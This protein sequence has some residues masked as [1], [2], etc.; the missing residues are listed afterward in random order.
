MWEKE[1]IPGEHKVYRWVKNS[2][3][4]DGE[5]APGAF[6]NATDENGNKTDGMSVNWEEYSTCLSTRDDL[7]NYGKNREEYGV[8][9]INVGE[10]R[11]KIDPSQEVE[12]AP[13]LNNS[14]HSEV[15]GDK[16]K[17]TQKMLRDVASVCVLPV[18]QWIPA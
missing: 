5:V 7:I 8:V 3:F 1:P 4:V 12:H 18:I 15:K 13:E 2:L 14:A 9:E 16:T 10:I 6:R 11:T 17:R